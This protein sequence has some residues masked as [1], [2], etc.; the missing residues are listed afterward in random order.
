MTPAIDLLKK[1]KLTFHVHQYE[2]DSNETQFG[3]EAVEKLDPNLHVVA[4]QVF[5]TL[6]VTLN[7]NIK[8]LAVCVVP[9]ERHLDLKKA[10]KALHCK[11]I[12]LADPH[13]A[14]KVTGY[15]VGGISPI[16]QKKQLPTLIDDSAKQFAT[17]FVSGGRRGLEIEISPHTLTAVLKAEFVEISV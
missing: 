5:K 1:L 2:H 4:E 8:E 15:L 7:D 17:M 16:G 14:Q 9:V 3:K 10:A 6:V 13:L 12:A 11:K